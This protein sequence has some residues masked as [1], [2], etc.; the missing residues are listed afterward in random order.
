[1]KKEQAYVFEMLVAFSEICT[2]NGLRF[3][4]VGGSLI[5]AV[6]E[7]GFIPWDDDIDVAMPWE[8]YQI[9]LSHEQELPKGYKLLTPQNFPEYPYY[10]AKVFNQNV[11]FEESEEY[12]GYG[13]PLDIFPF[14]PSKK[15]TFLV[16]FL[17]EVL[18]VLG[19]VLLVKSR[20]TPFVPYKKRIARF[21]FWLLDCFTARQLK[22]IRDRL[23]EF[24]SHDGTEY[25]FSPG[26]SYKSDKEF[27]PKQWFAKTVNV[28][29]CGQ[30]F[31]APQ[32]WQKYLN[33]NYGDYTIP[34]R[35]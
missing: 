26:G 27:Y 16:R 5:G 2:R 30:Q 23:I 14:L 19:Y 35:K 11:K 34:V 31:P 22:W 3:C 28:N 13:F 9:F 1:M 33:R 10:N 15:P 12:C 25:C 32:G 21:G 17:Y 6:R 18:C 7:H 20:W 24:I 29:F 8:D 4:L